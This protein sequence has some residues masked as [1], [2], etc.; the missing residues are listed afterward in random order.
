VAAPAWSIIPSLRYLQETVSSDTE[1]IENLLEKLYYIVINGT[2]VYFA[3]FY[4]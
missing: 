2:T 3:K 1:F 4:P